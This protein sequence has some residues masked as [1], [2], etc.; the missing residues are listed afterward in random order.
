MIFT[1]AS[2]MLSN[3]VICFVFSASFKMTLG[4][5]KSESS[6]PKGSSSS[7]ITPFINNLIWW[8]CWRFRFPPNLHASTSLAFQ[9][10]VLPCDGAFLRKYRKISVQAL[11]RVCAKLTS[12]IPT[13]EYSQWYG[14]SKCKRRAKTFN[15][16]RRPN[17]VVS[18]SAKILSLPILV[19]L[20]LN[21][22]RL[23][24]PS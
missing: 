13:S 2:Q 10:S 12:I 9:K 24:C 3:V 21:Q 22:M 7:S 20:I 19:S 18:V 5:S 23:S 11:F 14:Q 6:E 17:L 4:S 16:S 1:N 8:V 15:I